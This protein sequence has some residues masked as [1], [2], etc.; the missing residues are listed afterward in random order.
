V[1]PAI[2]AGIV[3]VTVAPFAGFGPAFDATIVY[4][5]GCPVTAVVCPSVL[6]TERS[7]P[8]VSVSVSVAEL[9]ARFGSVT[10]LGGN[11]VAVLLRLPVADELTV[12]VT[13]YVTVPPGGRFAVS[14]MWPD[15]L[16]VQLP[17]PAPTQI[18]VTPVIAAGTVSDTVA[19]SATLGPAFDTTMVYVMEDPRIAVAR[20]S[21]FVIER[22]AWDA[23]VSVSVAEL[24]ARLGSIIPAGTTTVAVLLRL[25]V[26]DRL[27]VPVR[28]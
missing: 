25:P 10:P 19:P 11:T 24:L 28:V 20:P 8:S 1:T 12:P 15:P 6:V 3:S 16:A 22:S 27:T 21:L 18:Q 13:V 2:V 5:I 17:P 23:S 9:L 7:V 26:A 4:V 14:L